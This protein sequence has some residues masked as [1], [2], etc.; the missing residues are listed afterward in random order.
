VFK[1][2]I[3]F[4]EYAVKKYGL[5]TPCADLGGVDN[6]VVIADYDITLR[7]GV[8][9]DRYLNLGHPP[10]SEVLGSYSIINP[11]KG[12]PPIELIQDR[13]KW[14]TCVCVSVLEHVTNPFDVM[15]NIY[16]IL[17]PGGLLV[18][19]TLF[20]FPLHES[21]PDY[22][23]NFR[24]APNGLEILAEHAGLLVLECGFRLKIYG[25]D[26]IKDIKNGHA[27]EI[28]SVGLIARK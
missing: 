17:K 5:M 7:T 27:Q 2:D 3:D 16:R 15:D 21:L 13:D 12:D 24:F 14:G 22:H 9:A 4:I 6:G 10:F 8:Q 19:S 18:L 26:G 11:D 28:M 1:D 25:E 20:S 23:D